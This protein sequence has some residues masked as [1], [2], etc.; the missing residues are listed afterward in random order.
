MR[1]M[2]EDIDPGMLTM[3][4]HT[5]IDLR[6]KVLD[7]QDRIHTLC[8]CIYIWY[9]VCT[10]MYMCMCTCTLASVPGLPPIYLSACGTW[11]VA[12]KNREGLGV[13][14]T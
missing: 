12:Y 10:Y 5:D 2:Q 3:S 13:S 6:G 8:T 4:E 14:I 1:V 11:I 9:V 7:V